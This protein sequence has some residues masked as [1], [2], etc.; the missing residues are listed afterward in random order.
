MGELTTE[1]TGAISAPPVAEESIQCLTFSVAGERFAVD[2]LEIREI[3]E[4]G[5][6]TSVPLAPDFVRGVVN[7]RGNVLPIGGF[8]KA[9]KSGESH[10]WGAQTMHMMQMACNTASY[11]LWKRYSEAMQANPP[12]QKN[13]Q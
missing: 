3:I 13:S 10:A 9:R 11:E 12:I 1:E 5:M 4:V 8:Y 7:L 6:M 2:I